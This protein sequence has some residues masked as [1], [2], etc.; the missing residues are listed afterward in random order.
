MS[1]RTFGDLRFVLIWSDEHG[2]WW[3]PDG[4]G[5]TQR[6]EEAGLY[7]EDEAVQRWLNGGSDFHHVVRL[8]K[9]R[10]P[11]PGSRRRAAGSVPRG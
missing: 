3:R 8:P 2:A 10:P 6:I 7:N 11:R 1:A 9:P 5:Y 4:M